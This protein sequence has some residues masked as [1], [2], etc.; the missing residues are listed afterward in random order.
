[1]IIQGNY[2]ITVRF[3]Y[4]FVSSRIILLVAEILKR[5]ESIGAEAASRGNHR[6]T[7]QEGLEGTSGD[8]VVQPSCYMTK[9]CLERQSMMVQECCFSVFVFRISFCIG[10]KRQITAI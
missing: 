10:E 2:D 7:E 8:H 1:M 5:K 6:I 3:S 4:Y 9:S